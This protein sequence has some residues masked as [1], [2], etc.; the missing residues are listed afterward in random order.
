MF[1]AN[2]I[3]VVSTNIKLHKQIY[4]SKIP[5]AS[6]QFQLNLNLDQT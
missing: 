5:F 1:E 2:P 4:F 3:N 6:S